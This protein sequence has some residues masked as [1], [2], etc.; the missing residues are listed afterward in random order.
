MLNQ[1]ARLKMELQCLPLHGDQP[2]PLLYCVKVAK[3]QDCKL[4]NA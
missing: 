3:L 2:A 1:V 4:E